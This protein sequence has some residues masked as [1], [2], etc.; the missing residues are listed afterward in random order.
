MQVFCIIFCIVLALAPCQLSA[1]RAAVLRSLKTDID[2]ILQQPEFKGATIGVHVTSLEYQ[3]DVYSN[4]AHTLLLPASTQKIFT[5]AAAL[6]ILGTNYTFTTTV[7]LDGVI[8]SNGEFVGTMIIRGSGDPSM[9]VS[10]GKTPDEFMDNIAEALDSLGIQSF[11][12]TIIGDD[13]VFDDQQYPDGWGWEDLAY[14]YAPQVGGLNIADNAVRVN[15][16]SPLSTSDIPLLKLQPSTDYV[17]VIPTLRVVDSSGATQI[18]P[19]REIRSNTVDLTGTIRTSAKRDTTRLN[20]AIENPT[21]YWL[22]LL[23][24]GLQRRGIRV[25]G[26]LVDIDDWNEPI[27]DQNCTTA[28]VLQSQPLSALVYA[29][30]HSSVN[31]ASEVLLKT[32]GVAKAGEGGFRKGA[33]IIKQWSN[34]SGTIVDGSGLSRLNLCSA[35]DLTSVLAK[36][37]ASDQSLVFRASLAAPGEDG[38]LKRRLTGTRV[39]G[40]LRAKTGSMNNVSTLAGYIETRDNEPLAFAI[41]INGF[42]GPASSAQALQDVICMRLAAL[43]KK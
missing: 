6:Q 31:L 38:T 29:I 32:I 1:Q 15:I 43:T 27:N 39:Q 8:Q 34:H 22:S 4:N 5:T 35:R 12:G 28:V 41:M 3:D 24:D 40:A 7:L 11:R 14:G 13:D 36:M 33:E 16:T 9:S 18:I 42:T 30:N 17:H 23:R 19:L 10:F 2:A 20:V 26:A 37:H 21:L 25:R